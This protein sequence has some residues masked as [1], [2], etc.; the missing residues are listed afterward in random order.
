[1]AGRP[2]VMA[3]APTPTKQAHDVSTAPRIGKPE[4][5]TQGHSGVARPVHCLAST[6]QSLRRLHLDDALLLGVVEVWDVESIGLGTKG[7]VP[8]VEPGALCSPFP[9][10]RAPDLFV[11]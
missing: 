10:W 5:A 6:P 3:I 9:G 7:W 2:R 4:R 11:E 8:R 1:M